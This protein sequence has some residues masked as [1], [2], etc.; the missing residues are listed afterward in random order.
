MTFV[1]N[2]GQPDKGGHGKGT[3][4]PRRERD[5]W[6]NGVPRVKAKR[7]LRRKSQIQR[8]EKADQR[9]ARTLWLHNSA[10][11][12]KALGVQKTRN[13]GTGG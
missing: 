9:A 3:L 7:Q 10:G 1:S 5:I 11:N 13:G 4:L 8:P 6:G 12:G 2:H